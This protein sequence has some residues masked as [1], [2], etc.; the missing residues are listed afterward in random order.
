MVKTQLLK[1]E[2]SFRGLGFV[3][4]NGLNVPICGSKRFQF[5]EGVQVKWRPRQLELVKPEDEVR[6]V[7]PVLLGDEGPNEEWYIRRVSD[8]VLIDDGI[9]MEGILSILGMNVYDVQ[10]RAP[11]RMRFP[12]ELL[13]G[14]GK[15]FDSLAPYWGNLANYRSSFETEI[16]I[17]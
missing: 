3:L 16:W 10:V 13:I 1:G 4:V 5:G 14:A 11:F 8:S 12:D 9:S 2:H 15:A 7:V 6:A 17:P